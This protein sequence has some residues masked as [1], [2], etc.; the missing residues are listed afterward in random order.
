MCLEMDIHGRSISN[1][2]RNSEAEELCRQEIFATRQ[3]P[4]LERFRRS[5][6][7]LRRVEQRRG[8]RAIA[9]STGRGGRG[10]DTASKAKAMGWQP[11]RG[12]Q[13]TILEVI[14]RASLATHGVA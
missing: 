13:G 11:V 6:D 8:A 9:A 1:M 10:G 14:S 12:D 3:H 2:A 5:D 4:Q 7:A